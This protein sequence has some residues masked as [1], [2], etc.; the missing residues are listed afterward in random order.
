MMFAIL[1]N[2]ME[3]FMEELVSLE[4]YVNHQNEEKKSQKNNQKGKANA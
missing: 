1:M 3:S 4:S 2:G